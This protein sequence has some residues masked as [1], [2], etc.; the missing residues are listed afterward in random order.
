MAAERGG[1]ER[2]RREAAESGDGERQRRAVAESSGGERRRRA[3]AKSGGGERQRREAAES[4][5]GERRRREAVERGGGERW[6]REAVERGGGERRRRAKTPN[7]R[8]R[9]RDGRLC[10][11]CW[12][13]RGGTLDSAMRWD[14]G[15]RRKSR[16]RCVVAEIGSSKLIAGVFT[17]SANSPRY[18]GCCGGRARRAAPASAG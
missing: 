13:P 1:G 5:G 8:L 2:W 18:R 15:R 9:E 10:W 17:V 3:A 7:G 4:E 14:C 6:R 11:I 12:V 16:G